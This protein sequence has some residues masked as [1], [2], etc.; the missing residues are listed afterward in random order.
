MATV[1]EDIATDLD[2]LYDLDFGF[3]IEVTGPGGDIVA[4][5]SNEYLEAD[6]GAS[7]GVRS[8]LPE[9]RTRDADAIAEGATVTIPKG[10]T[11]YVVTEPQPDGYGETI[12]RLRKL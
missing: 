4:L 8:A 5:F 6:A 12:H 3:A 1:L 2:D 10:G 11:D 9:L 7:I